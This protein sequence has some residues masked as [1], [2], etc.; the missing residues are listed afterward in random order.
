R[1]TLRNPP[2]LPTAISHDDDAIK[3]ASSFLKVS[4][5]ASL[6]NSD[7]FLFLDLF[8][9]RPLFA[10]ILLSCQATVSTQLPLG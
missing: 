3:S 5:Q 1:K 4:H 8:R 9:S 10:A 6:S 2:S 7:A